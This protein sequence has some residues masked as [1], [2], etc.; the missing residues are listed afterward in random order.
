MPPSERFFRMVAKEYVLASAYQCAGG[1]HAIL[2]PGFTTGP[3]PNV[4]PPP[5][6]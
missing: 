5:W 6:F 4:V 3:G 2:T 1:L